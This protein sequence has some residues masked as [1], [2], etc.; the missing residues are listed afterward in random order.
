M[1]LEKAMGS[2]AAA[3]Q[4]QQRP[5][6]REGGFLKRRWFEPV[7]AE[8]EV[9]V[10]RVRFWDQAATAAIKKKIDPDWTA[11]ARL[12]LTK[13]GRVTIEHISRLQETPHKVEKETKY[14]ATMDGP[15]CLIYIDQEPGASGK[16][17]IS[18]YQPYVLPGFTVR[19]MRPTGPKESYVDALAAYAE[20]GNVDMVIGEW[21]DDFL[22]QGEMFPMATH[23]DIVD[24]VSKAF[25]VLMIT[26]TGAKARVVEI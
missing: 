11:G 7:K 23:D 20:G 3:G 19:G 5:A 1:D 6:P 17:N 26:R 8:P 24:A 16:N 9:V 14:W 4:L 25:H 2:Y 12:S 10:A 15:G 18:F 21:N 22:S 13:D